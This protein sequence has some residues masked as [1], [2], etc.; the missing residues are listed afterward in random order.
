MAI[1][2]VMAVDIFGER[3]R[4]NFGDLGRAL[5]TVFR[6]TTGD[7]WSDLAT[8]EMLVNDAFVRRRR[9]GEVEAP[10]AS[11][12]QN[13]LHT[14]DGFDGAIELFFVLVVL[15]CGL[16]LTNV[17]VAVLLDEFIKAV[18]VEKQKLA[19]AA[20]EEASHAFE[21]KV[22]LDRLLAPLTHFNDHQDL[23]NKFSSLFH[24]FDVNDSGLPTKTEVVNGVHCSI[25]VMLSEEDCDDFGLNHKENYGGGVIHQ[26]IQRALEEINSD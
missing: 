6:V 18:Q 1:F 23:R 20:M 26:N 2:S 25:D 17:V 15:I 16:V 10:S 7:N 19:E 4:D 9:A 21:H 3:D 13:S 5:F 8:E 22:P 12:Q 11:D 14:S 24:L